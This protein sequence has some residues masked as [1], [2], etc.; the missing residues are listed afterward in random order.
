MGTAIAGRMKFS[1]ILLCFLSHAL[2]FENAL[3]RLGIQSLVA[4][5]E[6]TQVSLQVLSG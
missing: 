5:S 1:E 4:L 2:C 3:F 6:L